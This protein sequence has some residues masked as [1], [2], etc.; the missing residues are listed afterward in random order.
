MIV[1]VPKE[2]KNH[3]YRIA[4][5]PAGARELSSA[6]HRVLIEG[7]A[8]EGSR[9]S[10][11]DYKRAG[12]ETTSREA[13]WAESEMVLKVKEPIAEEFGSLGKGQILFTYLHLAASLD[14]TKA[15]LD[16]GTAGVA[17]ETVQTPDDRLPLLAPMSEVAG[18]M[19]P[20]VGAT[21]L[22][23][24]H[25]G[26]GILIGGV[27]GVHPA[28][29]VVLGAGMAGANAAW[30]AQGMEAEVIVL[31]RNID[32]LRHIDQI[33]KGRILTLTSNQLTIEESVLQA[34]LL[35]GAVLVPG[36][37][38]PKLI[39]K[40]LVGA[41]KPG[42]VVI[43]ISIDQGG[44]IETAKMTTHSDPTYRVGDIVHYC[45][46][47]MPGAVP[48]TSTYALT[49]A[50]LPYVMALANK[51][52]KRAADDDPELALGINT[53]E[54]QIVHEAVAEAHSMPF[55]PRSEVWA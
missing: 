39:S 41:M 28:K 13:V 42:A 7:G 10:D 27:S 47:N 18:R 33:H 26:R 35:I 23:K 11:D 29:V 40:E 48:H 45:V 49:N 31:D 16:S 4:L 30:L 50:T 20:H 53:L 17:Y 3:E 1:G 34:D 38:A 6:G 46:G 12:A 24:A 55:I 9:I 54:G 44:C 19:A 5:T 22:E 21:L 43:D 2:L 32:R 25:Q 36:A 15:L 8:G 14:V 37:R 52:L 51:G